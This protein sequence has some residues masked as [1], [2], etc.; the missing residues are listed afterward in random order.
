MALG[1]AVF[2]NKLIELLLAGKVLLLFGSSS[3]LAYLLYSASVHD[4]Y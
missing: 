4:F 2:G 1:L 3:L